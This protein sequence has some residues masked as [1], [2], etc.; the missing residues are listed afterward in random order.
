MSERPFHAGNGL[1]YRFNYYLA[2]D[3]VPVCLRAFQLCS[4]TTVRLPGSS[5]LLNFG[6][7]MGNTVMRSAAAYL[8]LVKK[9]FPV[10]RTAAATE[11]LVFE[12]WHS[13]HPGTLFTDFAQSSSWTYLCREVSDGAH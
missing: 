4:L 6:A 10:I 13:V 3:S 7:R 8:C 2:V 12:P 1:H 11:L 5:T 9:S